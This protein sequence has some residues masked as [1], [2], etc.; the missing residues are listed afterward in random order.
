MNTSYI[1]QDE[2][3]DNEENV[4]LN[5]NVYGNIFAIAAGDLSI[6]DKAVSEFSGRSFSSRTPELRVSHSGKKAA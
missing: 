3:A 1:L 2:A 4:A 6:F 5:D